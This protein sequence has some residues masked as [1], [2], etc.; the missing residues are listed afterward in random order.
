[1]AS[2]LPECKRHK[3]SWVRNVESWRVSKTRA[4]GKVRG[5]YRCE[6]CGRHKY[7]EMRITP[8]TINS[9]EVGHD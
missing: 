6:K 5:L 8:I 2:E 9:E 3:W 7:G 4:H 1:M